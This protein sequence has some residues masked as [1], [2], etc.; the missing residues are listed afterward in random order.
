MVSDLGKIFSFCS[1]ISFKQYEQQSGSCM[2]F[3]FSLW[4]DGNSE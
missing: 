1:G 2:K 3:T 4:F